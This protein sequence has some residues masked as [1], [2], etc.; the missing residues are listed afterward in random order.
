MSTEKPI[1]FKGVSVSIEHHIQDKAVYSTSLPSVAR[2][3]SKQDEYYA[4]MAQ[5]LKTLLGENL[6]HLEV[7]H[8]IMINPGPGSNWVKDTSAPTWWRHIRDHGRGIRYPRVGSF[9][10]M[11]RLPSAWFLQSSCKPSKTTGSDSCLPPRCMAWS[12]LQTRLWP[13]IE[14]LVESISQLVTAAQANQ[15]MEW[16]DFLKSCSHQDSQNGGSIACTPVACT[17]LLRDAGICPIAVTELKSRLARPGRPISAESARRPHS[18]ASVGLR[19]QRQKPQNIPERPATA[20]P[21]YPEPWVEA[22]WKAKQLEMSKK[23]AEE[24]NGNIAQ[25]VP[26]QVDVFGGVSVPV[27]PLDPEKHAR[28][29]KQLKKSVAK[30]SE[31]AHFPERPASTPPGWPDSWVKD[32]WET[33]RE[34]AASEKPGEDPPPQVINLL[35]HRYNHPPWI[36]LLQQ[37]DWKVQLEKRELLEARE[38]KAKEMPLCFTKESPP[39]PVSMEER[40][41]GPVIKGV[42]RDAKSEEHYLATIIGRTAAKKV[43]SA[44]RQKCVEDKK[45][46]L[47]SV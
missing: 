41:P 20:E 5:E 47:F 21:G 26:V 28:I 35:G 19:R 30:A 32:K 31:A 8:R 17:P 13:E 15:E 33:K 4:E 12:M 38:I 36:R 9:E 10:V 6:S 37:P 2:R 11:V 29:Y 42:N 34:K 27:K 40:P 39:A 3:L 45:A 1:P 25:P 46:P 23:V 18:S 44:R 22:K 14:N 16:H 24:A 43:M 7:Q